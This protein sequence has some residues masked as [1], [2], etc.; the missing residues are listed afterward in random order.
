ML[1]VGFL[2]EIFM[3]FIHPII[4]IIIEA[5]YSIRALRIRF[6]APPCGDLKGA[7][8]QQEKEVGLALP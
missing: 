3:N 8:G 6:T 1:R 5:N 7:L 4:C 2:N